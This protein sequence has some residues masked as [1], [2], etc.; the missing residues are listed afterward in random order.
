MDRLNILSREE[1]KFLNDMKQDCLIIG[2]A[3]SYSYGTETSKSDIDIRGIR[4]NSPETILGIKAPSFYKDNNTDTTIYDL[5]KVIPLLTAVNPNIIEIL[6]LEPED[7]IYIDKY[8]Y[9]LIE[10]ADMFL[11]KNKIRNAFGG[12]A[13][14]QLK[15][16]ENTHMDKEHCCKHAMHL[17]RLLMTGRD[18][19]TSGKIKTKVNKKDLVTLVYIR[20]GFFYNENNPRKMTDQF[21][22]YYELLEEDFHKAYELSNLPDEPNYDKI[23]DMLMSINYDTV[24]LKYEQLNQRKNKSS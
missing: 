9:D 17:I 5:N 19:L 1:Y 2:L 24:L 14:A 11:S 8:G 21:Y 3:G 12:Y 23:R 13:T 18:I 20:H 7:Y 15:K 4:Y 10:N 22:S 16:L 6:G